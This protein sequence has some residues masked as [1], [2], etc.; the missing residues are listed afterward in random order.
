[1]KQPLI[2]PATMGAS[3]VA[4]VAAMLVGGYKIAD[5]L[6]YQ[7]GPSACDQVVEANAVTIVGGIAAVAGPLGGLFTYN[8]GLEPPG[9]RRRR[10]LEGGELESTVPGPVNL[11]LI[12]S[13]PRVTFQL[14]EPEPPQAPAA[15]SPKALP[16]QDPWLEEGGI[17]ARISE[18]AENGW[19]QQGIAEFLGVTLYRV[20]KALGRL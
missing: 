18:L 13:D 14:D 11:A 1:M 9:R 16:L 19:T 6:R 3:I 20:R 12:D 8:E 2:A 5:C 15:A 10:R 7:A 4:G 17:D